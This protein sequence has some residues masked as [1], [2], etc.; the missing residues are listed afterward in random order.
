MNLD[1]AQFKTS[2]FC[3][4]AAC[5]EVARLADGHVAVRDNKNLG[6]PA[7]VFTADEWSAFIAGA[8]AGEFD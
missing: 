1:H 7:L 3:S 8:K 6:R 5:V 4:A 2:S